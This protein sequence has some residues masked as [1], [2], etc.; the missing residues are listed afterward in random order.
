MKKHKILS[1]SVIFLWFN[2][3]FSQNLIE[4]AKSYSLE[5]QFDYPVEFISKHKIK[6]ISEYKKSQD[7]LTTFNAQYY[8]FNKLGKP[9]YKKNVNLYG[10]SVITKYQY[11]HQN[12]LL[13][14]TVNKRSEIRLSER[15]TS[16]LFEWIY[17]E[18]GI[19]VEQYEYGMID[20]IPDSKGNGGWGF[21]PKMM[22][23]K[24][25]AY[26]YDFENSTVQIENQCKHAK[27]EIYPPSFSIQV[28]TRLK[29]FENGKVSEKKGESILGDNRKIETTTKYDQK[30]NEIY[31]NYNSTNST[32]SWIFPKSYDPIEK[33]KI[34]QTDTIKHTETGDIELQYIIGRYFGDRRLLS[35][36]YVSKLDSIMFNKIQSPFRKSRL[37]VKTGDIE[38]QYTLK[39]AIEGIEVLKLVYDSY[40]SLKYSILEWFPDDKKNLTYSFHIKKYSEEKVV[41][42]EDFLSSGAPTNFSGYHDSRGYNPP[43][44]IYTK[45]VYEYFDNGILKKVSLYNESNNPTETVCYDSGS[46]FEL[47]YT[48]NN[49]PGANIYYEIEYYDE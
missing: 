49:I 38:I 42:Q 26:T 17:D 14:K 41:Y 30:G 37:P 33:N 45:S 39:S 5:N 19:L 1:F 24:C 22:I 48:L 12:N 31:K 23:T 6:S 44:D 10:D 34:L 21:N 16:N 43:R 35:E 15:V 27:Y 46:Q 3:G 4:S 20:F 47:S 11:D 9:L 28:K 18:N 8:Q 40:K 29:F 2:Y 36:N 32:K 13:S 25:L 7:G